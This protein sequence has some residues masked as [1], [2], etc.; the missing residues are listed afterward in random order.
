M[1]DWKDLED[2]DEFAQYWKDFGKND[3]DEAGDEDDE[4]H[5]GIRA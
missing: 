5:A 2:E 1:Q 4:P 3:T